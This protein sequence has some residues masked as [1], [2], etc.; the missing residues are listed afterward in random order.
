MCSYS[1]ASAHVILKQIR[2]RLRLVVSREEKWYPTILRV[3]F[4][5]LY[6]YFELFSYTR[7]EKVVLLF[8][9]DNKKKTH[10]FQI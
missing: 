4:E 9:L 7:T 1:M 10:V 3:N 8:F 6:K 2:Q 5:L